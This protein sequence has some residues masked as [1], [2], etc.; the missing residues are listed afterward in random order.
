MLICNVYKRAL[1]FSFCFFIF[2]FYLLCVEIGK[3]RSLW[4]TNTPFDFDFDFVV[5]R[6]Q[7]ASFGF[8]D[9]NI[10]IK[11]APLIVIRILY[12]QLANYNGVSNSLLANVC[13]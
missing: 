8:G 5:P 4:L 1:Y 3:T 7:I 10:I 11:T 2:L 9:V 12:L 13:K 6:G